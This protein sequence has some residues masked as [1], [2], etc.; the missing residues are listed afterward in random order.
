MSDA[1]WKRYISIYTTES[2]DMDSN[3]LMASLENAFAASGLVGPY[4]TETN[5]AGNVK[6][7][8]IVKVETSTGMSG[9]W[10]GDHLIF[11]PV[12]SDG[13][14]ERL[15]GILRDSMLSTLHARSYSFNSS[16][17]TI[18]EAAMARQTAST[19]V[20]ELLNDNKAK[21]FSKNITKQLSDTLIAK[22][23]VTISRHESGGLT[24]D[25]M[26][27]IDSTDVAS[28]QTVG[29]LASQI[30][31]SVLKAHEDEIEHQANGIIVGR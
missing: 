3:Q 26:I 18:V 29:E 23:I 9:V 22:D 1:S 25:M 16:K 31:F 8:P 12:G 27:A 30:S 19:E 15:L 6:G 13:D 17:R 7:A 11:V 10:I 5:I 2:I 28:G 4:N 21:E 24:V 14:H 20:L